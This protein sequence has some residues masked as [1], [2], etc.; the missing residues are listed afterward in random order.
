MESQIRSVFRRDNEKLTAQQICVRI[1]GGVNKRTINP[2][3]YEMQR[4]NELMCTRMVDVAAPFW[5]LAPPGEK[6]TYKTLL[7]EHI[8]KNH[9]CSP[10][11][12]DYEYPG[13]FTCSIHVNN[14]H[15]IGDLKYTKKAARQDA[16]EKAYRACMKEEEEEEEVEDEEIVLITTRDQVETWLELL[17]KRSLTE[18]EDTMTKWLESHEK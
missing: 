7:Q 18:L 12:V 14:Q 5:S 8:Q 6:K 16:E 1:G 17:R 11:Y 13:G 4:N 3:L 15:F 2:V 10:T 9:L